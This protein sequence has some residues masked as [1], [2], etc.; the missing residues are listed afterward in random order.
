MNSEY[1]REQVWPLRDKLYRI[2]LRVLGA[3]D[4]A[5]DVAQ[6]AMIKLWEQR[7]ELR[8]VN[9]LE[10]WCV[11][12]AR[13]LSIDKL[14]S[15]YRK[16]RTDLAEATT[17]RTADSDPARRAQVSDT[18][19]RIDRIL[20]AMPEPR[21]SILHLRDIEE[22]TYQE[23]CDALDVTLSQVK[24]ELHR[25]RKHLREALVKSESYGL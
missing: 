7:T 9:N 11:R 22:Y 1:F 8:K 25:G 20:Q 13:N 12:L 17:V 24:I 21:R 5:E 19:A 4:E 6:E 18:F 10:S 14:R 15:G 2:S 3:A 16:R 23:I